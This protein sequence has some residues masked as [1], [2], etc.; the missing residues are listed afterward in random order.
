MYISSNKRVCQMHKCKH[1]QR[2][3]QKCVRVPERNISVINFTLITD[4]NWCFLPIGSGEKI[5]NTMEAF[6]QWVSLLHGLLFFY[7]FL[8]F[9]TW[10]MCLYDRVIALWMCALTCWRWTVTLHWMAVLWFHMIKTFWDS[11]D[12]TK[13]YRLLDSRLVILTL[14]FLFSSTCDLWWI[15]NPTLYL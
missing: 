10:T 3:T 15:F 13:Q 4:I 5:E 9:S 1:L 12:V 2:V 8:L 6:T 11:R 7:P 14:N